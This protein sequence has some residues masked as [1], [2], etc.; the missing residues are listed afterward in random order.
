MTTMQENE[1]TLREAG[2]RVTSPRLATLAA[3][4]ENQHADAEVIA[5]AVRER[6]GSVSK[7]AVYDV[8]YALTDAGLVRRMMTDDRRNRFEIQ[9]HDNH[10]HVMCRKC[11]VIEDI[12][13]PTGAAPCLQPEDDF[14][15]AIDEADVIYRGLCPRCRNE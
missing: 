13:C 9:R 6:L 5:S 15:F 3:V 11:G 14:G 2:L 1:R 12:P 4:A 7:Q 10:H 8:L